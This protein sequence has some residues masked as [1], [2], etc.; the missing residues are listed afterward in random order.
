M[1]QIIMLG[2]FVETIELCEE[3]GYDIVGI[4]DNYV[5]GVYCGY[6]ILGRDEDLILQKDKYINI[7]LV[8]VPDAPRVRERMYQIYKENGF[9]FE[10]V[11]SPKAIISKSAFIDEGCIIQAGCNIS[12]EV[13]LGKCVRVNTFANIMHET[14]VEDFSIVA[15]NAVI[16]GRCRVGKK[17]YIGANATILPNRLVRENAI[18]GAAAVVTKDVAVGN[19]VVGNPAR[20]LKDVE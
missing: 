14:F 15:Q 10:T 13:K 6:P 3:C 19:V 5:Q 9:S 1:K 16:L 12:S 20:K 2:A 11:I 18:V 8:I 17:S 7:P 4:F